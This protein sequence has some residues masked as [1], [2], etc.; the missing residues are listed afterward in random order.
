MTAIAEP[1][2][3]S[4]DP[5]GELIRRG[6]HREAAARCAEQHG[7]ALGRMCMAL[8]ASQ[9]EAEEAVQEALLAAYRGMGAYRGDASARA[10]LFG[11]ARKVCAR[12]LAVRTRQAKRL[13]LVHD[14][15]AAAELPDVDAERRERAVRLR[16]ALAQL[17]PS[18]REAV[19]LRYQA[20][21][22]YREVAEACGIEEPAARKRASR[23]LANLR[24]L[25]PSEVV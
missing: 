24:K 1:N 22:S 9:A 7:A 16:G 12:R 14:A 21:L 23:A 8:L 25:L 20:G 15:G 17:K 5:L 2:A 13:R 11:I 10:W 3:A 19:L 6:S 4:A 18:E